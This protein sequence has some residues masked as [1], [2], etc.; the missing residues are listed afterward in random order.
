MPGTP[1]PPAPPPAPQSPLVRG[2]VFG[3]LHIHLNLVKTVR[4]ILEG[5]NN[6]LLCCLQFPLPPTPCHFPPWRTLQG[7]PQTNTL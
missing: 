4:G 1:P 6:F 5:E 3:S 7:H 2:M